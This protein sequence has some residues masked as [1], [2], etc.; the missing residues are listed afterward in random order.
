MD[1]KSED[2]KKTAEKMK[3]LREM[4]CDSLT[5]RLGYQQ[6]VWEAVS[7]ANWVHRKKKNKNRELV[8][9]KAA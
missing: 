2:L 4:M 7:K 3:V 6:C 9:N 5:W 1:S 8:K